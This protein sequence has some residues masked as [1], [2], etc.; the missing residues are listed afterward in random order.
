MFAGDAKREEKQVDVIISNPWD[1]PQELDIATKGDVV[2]PPTPATGLPST[3]GF[4]VFLFCCSVRYS[5]APH[6]QFA[7]AQ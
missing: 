4:A 1:L 2:D 3:F 7:Q 6:G 5:R